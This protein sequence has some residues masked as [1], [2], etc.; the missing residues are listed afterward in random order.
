MKKLFV[1]AAILGMTSFAF[2]QQAAGSKDSKDSKTC[3]KSCSDK[4]CCKGDGSCS[5]SSK[6]CKSSAA[7]TTT[8]KTSDK[9]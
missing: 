8:T 3:T 6:T 1:A 2:G 9:K 5:K 7:A 4:K